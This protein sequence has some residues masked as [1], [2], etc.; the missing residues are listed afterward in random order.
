MSFKLYLNILFGLFFLNNP[1]SLIG[2]FLGYD[3][4]FPLFFLIPFVILDT[5]YVVFKIKIA[6]FSFIEILL[7]FFIII[8]FFIG[9]LNNEISRKTF[10]DFFIVILFLF[11][12]L[13]FKSEI[14]NNYEFIKYFIK[15]KLPYFLLSSFITVSLFIIFSKYK[16]IYA[17][18]TLQQLPYFTYNLL[19]NSLLNILFAIILVILSGKRASLLSFL[20]I[21]LIYRFRGISF[22]KNIIYIFILS[23]GLIFIFNLLDSYESNLSN[24]SIDK[25]LYTLNETKELD[26]FTNLDLNSPILDLLTAGRTSEI[27]SVLNDMNLIDYFLGKGCGYV[28]LNYRIANDEYFENHSNIHF[29]PLN[30]LSKYGILFFLFFYIY[31]IRGLFPLEKS[32]FRSFAQLVVLGYI[33]ESFFSYLY[34]VDMLFPLFIAIVQ[35]KKNNDFQIF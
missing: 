1:V 31:L 10:S 33:F 6:K 34:F 5:I 30:I 17:G 18:L 28:Y 12:V 26:E 25:Y 21:F 11:K 16:F 13:I 20:V 8:S 35:I 19:N 29:S 27:S 15:K 24:T 32:T 3:Y 4:L 2:V 7:L 14:S 22:F 23:F 9:I